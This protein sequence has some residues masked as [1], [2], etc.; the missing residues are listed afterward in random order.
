MSKQKKY[1][2][3]QAYSHNTKLAMR[4]I[5]ERAKYNPISESE[6]KIPDFYICLHCKKNKVKILYDTPSNIEGLKENSGCFLNGTVNYMVVGYGSIH[7][8]DRI[9]IALCDPCITKLSNKKHIL[10][11]P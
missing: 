9:V 3:R 2:I 11:L 8:L 5:K 7:D 10:Q 6:I 1:T 4:S